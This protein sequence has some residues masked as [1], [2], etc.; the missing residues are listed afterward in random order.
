MADLYYKKTQPKSEPVPESKP[1]IPEAV[2][3]VDQIFKA[4]AEH[5]DADRY[6]SLINDNIKINGVDFQ[7]TKIGWS[8]LTGRE[9][10]DVKWSYPQKYFQDR[11]SA[12]YSELTG[13]IKE[14]ALEPRRKDIEDPKYQE[15]ERA[16][17]Q[18][19]YEREREEKRREDRRNIFLLA[20]AIITF[21]A[22]MLTIGYFGGFDQ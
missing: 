8:V 22:A 11:F 16:R 4:G 7:R 5:L 21:V 18:R 1:N 15:K 2:T 10:F 3:E 14:R 13:R 20:A 9:V 17:L 12:A 19:K 6:D